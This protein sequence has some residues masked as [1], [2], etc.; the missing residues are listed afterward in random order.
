MKLLSIKLKNFRQFYG[1]TPKI[2]I[3]HGDRN[4]VVVLGE[5]G[6]GKTALLNAFTWALFDSVTRGFEN[7]EQI[8]NKR[9]IREA[10]PGTTVEAWVEIEFKHREMNHRLTRMAKATRNAEGWENHEPSMPELLRSEPDGK[11][12]PVPEVSDAIGKILPKDLHAY[13]FFDGERIERIVQ[14]TEDEREEVGKAAKKMLGV[15]ILVRAEEHLNKARR[16]LEEE[17]RDFGDERIAELIDQKLAMEKERDQLIH[18]QKEITLNVEKYQEIIKSNKDRLRAD[19]QSRAIQER[20]DHLEREKNARS[21]AYGSGVKALKG[22]LSKRAYLLFSDEV[23]DKFD[24]LICELTKR[25]EIPSGIKKNFVDKLLQDKQCI[26]LTS[27][28]PG[29]AERRSVEEWFHKAGLD[30]V[31]QKA[32]RMGGEIVQM[33]HKIEDVFSDIDHIQQRRAADYREMSR[34]EEELE[35]IK[36]SLRQNPP[37][38]DHKTLQLEIDKADEAIENYWKEH[39][40]NGARLGILN[41]DIAEK[42]KEIEKK[43][44][45]EARQALATRRVQA[46]RESA[47]RI[48]AIRELMEAQ[49]RKDL[50]DK[51]VELFRIISP[52]PYTPCVGTDYSLG[53]L[54]SAGGSPARVGKGTGESQIL[55]LSFI[56]SIISIVREKQSKGSVVPM[57][58]TNSYPL[59]MDSPFGAL[60]MYRHQIAEHMPILADQVGLFV[61]PKQWQGDVESSI[62][63]KLGK[64]YV[65]TK[66][67]PRKDIREVSIV[68]QGKKWDLVKTSPNDYEYSELSEVI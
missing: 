32:L 64:A 42:Q 53:L 44:A 11:W 15:E 54:E 5:N 25:G 2:V 47:E 16:R 10:T 51:I 39:G 1:E 46:A 8:V 31:E 36:D 7:I 26:C 23:I 21:E 3:P 30:E 13:F 55:S 45:A 63:P 50:E 49:F 28:T 33:K 67:T 40:A 9:A 62:M 29:S 14:Q 65:I 34:L 18:R 37:R 60:S 6:G 48:T 43:Q 12:R 57:P 22:I 68:L 4:V 52:T 17:L 58:D 59:I 61:S 20:S 41:R 38:E 19:E 56:G 66:N 27:L 35:K 24:R